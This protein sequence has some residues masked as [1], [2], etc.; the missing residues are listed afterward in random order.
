MAQLK[1]AWVFHTNVMNYFT[2]FESQP[3]VAKGV[4][5]IT[6]PHDHVYAL[7]AA[8]GDVKWTY[9]PPT[10]NPS[11]TYRPVAGRPIGP[12]GWVKEVI[13]IAVLDALGIEWAAFWGYSGGAAVGYALAAMHP[14]RI[15]AFVA[16]SAIGKGDWAISGARS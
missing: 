4:L 12:S 1:P 7:D 15:A 5:Y 6:S 9:S 11:P 10:C 14:E 13:V 16:Q 3:I 8:T 2:S